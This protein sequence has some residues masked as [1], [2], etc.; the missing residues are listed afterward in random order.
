MTMYKSKD[1]TMIDI[2]Y[3]LNGQNTCRE[4]KALKH[5]KKEASKLKEYF[6]R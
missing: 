4:M 1:E 3:M 2:F 5:L 6:Y